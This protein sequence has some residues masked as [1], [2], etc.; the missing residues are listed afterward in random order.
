MNTCM[1]VFYTHDAVVLRIYVLLINTCIHTHTHAHAYMHAGTHQYMHTHTHTAELKRLGGHVR[2]YIH[3]H[4]IRRTYP[5]TYT[6]YVNAHRKYTH[7]YI[8][9]CTH[10]YAY[11][12]SILVS[13]RINTYTH[14]YIQAHTGPPEHVSGCSVP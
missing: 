7:Q 14:T 2:I 8:N 4:P 3:T 9:K 1:D 10:T 11:K 13:R 6:I 12:G 5:T